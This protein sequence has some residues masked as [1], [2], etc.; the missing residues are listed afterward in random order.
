MTGVVESRLDDLEGFLL[1]C[2]GQDVPEWAVSWSDV[3]ASGSP[4]P[5]NL[6]VEEDTPAFVQPTTGTTG[7]PKPWIV[8]QRSWAAVVN[9]NL[10]HLDTFAD[11][12]CAFGPG[13]V[14]MHIHPLQWVTGF[15]LLYPGIIRGARTLLVDDSS[16]DPE[17]VWLRYVSARTDSVKASMRRVR[18]AMRS[19]R[20]ASRSV[21]LW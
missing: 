6:G 20:M 10:H 15:Q 1:V 4:A 18:S 7:Q 21:P 11:G 2:V 8:T 3:S 12:I 5:H 16:F 13:D 17:G 14:M 19:A 9:Q